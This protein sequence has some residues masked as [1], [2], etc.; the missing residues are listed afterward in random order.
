MFTGRNSDS[1]GRLAVFL[2]GNL[3]NIPG[4][5]NNLYRELRNP[6][7]CIGFQFIYRGPCNYCGKKLAVH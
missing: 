5:T 7:Q 4:K 3:V 1:Q 6:Q 2:G